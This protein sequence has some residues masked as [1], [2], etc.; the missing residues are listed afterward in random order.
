MADKI[1]IK[2][3]KVVDPRSSLHGKTVDFL[4]EDN[5]IQFFKDGDSTDGFEVITAENLH[6]SPGWFD[7]GP[8][9][10]DPGL[11]HKED[12]D[13]GLDA[14]LHGGFTSVAVGPNTHPV[15]DSKTGVDY[16][17][18]F[19][20]N[21]WLQVF[22][23]ASF[24]KNLKGEALTELYDMHEAGAIGF[25]HSDVPLKNVALLKLAMQYNRTLPAPLQVPAFDADLS[26][27]GQMHEGEI[28]T[29]IGLK[30]IPALAETITLSRDLQLAEYAETAVHFNGISS[31]Q[32]VQKIKEAKK[33][34]A[35]VSADVSIANLYFTD[36]DLKEYDANLKTQPPVRSAADRKALITGLKNGTLDFVRSQH[37]PQE[38]EA[39]KCEFDFAAFGAV[40]LEA[41]FGALNRATESTLSLDKRIEL[42]AYGPREML[43]LEIPHIEAGNEAVLSF[44]NPDTEWTFQLS[45][46]KSK[47]KNCPFVG[48]P[49]K[50]KPLGIFCNGTLAWSE[51]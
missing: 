50:G 32:G 43:G 10:G 31:A 36:E 20:N 40:T 8:E 26:H 24:S 6:V 46:V 17:V 38:I 42:L 33:A 45:D 37:R 44:F 27:T 41:T 48:K 28:S 7:V 18:N 23:L 39:K 25:S 47:S 15:I 9:F 29:L 4:F 35:L 2:G 34:G 14:A 30:G 49:M 19:Q 22:P 13:T 5:T 21:H 3:A 12:L 16:I 51:D 11:E 1:I